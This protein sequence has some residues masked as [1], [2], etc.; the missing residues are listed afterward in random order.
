M[1][2]F[3]AIDLPKDIRDSIAAI[4]RDLKGVRGKFVEPHN[5][6]ITL[7]FLGEQ[8]PHTVN[9]VLK[10]L[11]EITYKKFKVSVTGIGTFNNRVIWLGVSNG[12]EDILKLHSLVDDKLKKIGFEK[13]RNFHP[14][15]TIFRVKQILDKRLFDSFL[16]RNNKLYIGSFIVNEFKLKRSILTPEGPIYSDVGTFE[17]E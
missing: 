5:L 8:P 12:F 3:I 11:S 2:V 6:H 10:A 9:N 15:I 7:K 13:E 4:Y 14:H 1:R 16:E 17:L